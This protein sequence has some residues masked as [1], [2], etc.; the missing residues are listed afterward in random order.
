MAIKEVLHF[1]DGSRI[2]KNHDNT[3]SIIGA[4]AHASYFHMLEVCRET[5][6]ML[7]HDELMDFVKETLFDERIT[8]FENIDKLERIEA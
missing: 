5:M 2:E 7:S 6:P 1:T 4:D 8:D 3:L